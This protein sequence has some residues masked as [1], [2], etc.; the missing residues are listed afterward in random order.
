MNDHLH[1]ELEHLLPDPSQVCTRIIV[2]ALIDL[3]RVKSLTCQYVRCP[4]KSRK[5]SSG[6]AK[7]TKGLT[8]D[9]VDEQADD[10]PENIAI[11]HFSCNCSKGGHYVW[12]VP[13]LRKKLSRALS[14]RW[15]NKSYRKKKIKQM[16]GE[17]HW[18]KKPGAKKSYPRGDDHWS[19]KPG[20]RVVL[21]NGWRKRRRDNNL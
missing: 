19:R 20:A 6:P 15:K 4:F 1:R 17:N 2:H 9:H 16:S 12:S 14:D 13:A 10:R 7:N 3:G 21:K 8:I 5:F 11:V 18:S